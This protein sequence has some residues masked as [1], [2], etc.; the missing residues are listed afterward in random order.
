LIV[1]VQDLVAEAEDAELPKVV[2]APAERAF[3]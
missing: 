2:A 3:L 1:D